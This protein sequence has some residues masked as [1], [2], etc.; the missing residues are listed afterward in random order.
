MLLLHG[1][2]ETLL[3]LFRLAT[4]HGGLIGNAH[5]H[6]MQIGIK[7][8]RIGPLETVQKLIPVATVKDVIA[9]VVGL[10]EVEHHQIMP[11]PVGGGLG[12]CRLG[13]LVLGLAVDNTRHRLFAVLAHPLPDRHDVTAGRIDCLTSETLDA[14]AGR[15]LGAKRRNNDHVVGIES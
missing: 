11:R 10:G 12:G 14:V 2:L 1:L 5:G 9:N 15:H 7:A 8:R 3:N 6:Q 13:L 4:Q